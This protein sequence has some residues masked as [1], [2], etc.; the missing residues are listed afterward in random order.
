[1]DLQRKML[2]ELMNPL[3][4][5][6]KKDFT[7]SDV[8]KNY[9]VAFCPH[10]QFQNTKAGRFLLILDI[11]KC[12]LLHDQKLQKEYQKQ[13]DKQKYPYERKFYDLLERLL[14]DVDRTIKKQY[15]R[16]EHNSD[17]VYDNLVLYI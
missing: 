12:S 15:Q 7:D 6:A 5:E 14:A 3:I 11:G 16:L 10:E 13:P 9:L 1:M 8:C 4:P 2:E 17:A